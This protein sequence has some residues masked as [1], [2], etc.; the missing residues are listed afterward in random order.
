MAYA[1]SL[2][3]SL[4]PSP[5]S[6]FLS[7]SRSSLGESR[8]RFQP[9]R[10]SG[11]FTQRYVKRHD[12]ARRGPGTHGL[13]GL[14]FPHSISRFQSGFWGWDSDRILELFIGKSYSPS[15]LTCSHE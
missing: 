7:F 8:T 9:P 4:T 10:T 1:G 5:A 3:R 14:L 13:R 11:S 15:K 2:P 6:F 12:V